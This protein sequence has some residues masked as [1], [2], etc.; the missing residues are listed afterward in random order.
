MEL[1]VSLMKRTLVSLFVSVGTYFLSAH[2]HMSDILRAYTLCFKQQVDMCRIIE[3]NSG[4]TLGLL[5]DLVEQIHMLVIALLLLPKS[6]PRG[7]VSFI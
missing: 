6:P 2:L 4:Q 7:A 3:P 1:A 5:G